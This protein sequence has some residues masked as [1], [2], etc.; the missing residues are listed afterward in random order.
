[1]HGDREKEG[2]ADPALSISRTMRPLAS[3]GKNTKDLRESSALSTRP[4][5]VYA[6]TRRRPYGERGSLQA[7]FTCKRAEC[8]QT[9]IRS[10]A[11]PRT[12]NTLRT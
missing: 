5:P 9:L 8:A 10:F 1:M 11:P 2:E 4:Q 12:F 7:A 6:L 3:D